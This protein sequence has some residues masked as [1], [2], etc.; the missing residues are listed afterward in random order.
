VSG[1]QNRIIGHGEEQADQLLAN[2]KNWRIHPKAQQEALAGALDQVGWVQSV[3]VNRTTGHLVDGHLR[4]ELAL[5]RDDATVPV[6]YVELTPEE[7]ALVLASLDPISAMAARDDEKLRQLLAEV[8]FDNDALA[9]AIEALAPP[10]LPIISDPDDVPEVDDSDV[11]V[12]R[13]E[14]WRLGDHRILCGDSTDPDAVGRLFGTEEADVMWTDPPYGVAYQTPE[15]MLVGDKYA[16]HRRKDGL[17]VANDDLGR[18]ETRDLIVAAF[19]VAPMKPGAPF[20]VASPSGDMETVFREALSEAGWLLRQHLVW[21]KD[22]F[23][24]GRQDYQPRHETIL[25]GWIEGAAHPWLGG[26]SLTTVIEVP[27]PKK[28]E[29]HPTMKPVELVAHCLQNS[30][31]RGALVF[32]PFSGSGSTII[33]A[34]QLGLR[35]YAIELEPRYA[36]VAIERWQNATGRKAERQDG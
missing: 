24:F 22:Q 12:K 30:A 26:R 23:V 2:P 18:E 3:I 36:Q 28:S 33:A 13:G 32:E 6:A 11:Y 27:R 17:R 15:K 34:E 21:V 20:Y 14:V 31:K 10:E 4:V 7:E 1:W 8:E 9:D 29:E 25:Y 16:S 5:S 35:C 19:R